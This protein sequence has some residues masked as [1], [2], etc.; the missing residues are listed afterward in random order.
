[1]IDSVSY[2]NPSFITSLAGSKITG[3]VANATT[4]V[5][6]SAFTINQ[7][8]GTANAPTFAG[9]TTT[10][11]IN[12]QASQSSVLATAT[13]GLGGI[14][15][16][17][18]GGGNA[19]F[20]TFHR[21][22]A[23]AAYFGLD[24]TEF[25]VGGWSMGAVAYT[26]LHSGNYNAY[27]P[28]LTGTG[29][30]GNWGINVTGTSSNIT[31]FTINQNLGTTNTPTFSGLSVSNGASFATTSGSVGIANS[32]PL[33]RLHV[34]AVAGAGGID[35]NMTLSAGTNMIYQVATSGAALTWNANT[36]GSF[37]NTVMAQLKPRQDTS[38]NYNLDVFCGTWNNNN[39]AGTAIA[40]FQST[41]NVGIGTTTPTQKLHV[42]GTIRLDT[43]GVGVLTSDATGVVSSIKT[44]PAQIGV[45]TTTSS[46][47]SGFNYIVGANGITLSLPASATQGEKIGFVPRPGINS[48]TINRNGNN[49]MGLAENLIIDVQRPFALVYDNA[50]N[51][52]LIAHA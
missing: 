43:L 13:G 24:G 27:S 6:I 18:G 51:G 4:A 41:G 49:I 22:G 7:N 3:T 16:Y 45:V 19:A 17:G 50:T 30:S 42:N 31:S 52:W 28:T 33:T 11:R 14:E 20:M 10:G 34:G 39:S 46:I 35:G 25:K 1:L 21:P 37:S 8:L 47:S 12:A 5:N 36:N 23:F 38:A 40:T 29:A 26:L 15:L 44:L 2:S 48:Y 9:L 32:S